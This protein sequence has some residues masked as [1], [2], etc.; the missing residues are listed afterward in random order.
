MRAISL[1][2]QL[3]QVYPYDESPKPQ[4]PMAPGPVHPS[5]APPLPFHKYFH[6]VS[7]FPSSDAPFTRISPSSPRSAAKRRGDRVSLRRPSLDFASSLRSP[8]PSSPSPRSRIHRL[9]S[10]N[11]EEREDRSLLVASPETGKLPSSPSDALSSAPPVSPSSPA[12][13]RQQEALSQSVVVRKGYPPHLKTARC[14]FFYGQCFVCVRV[15]VR[16]CV[17]VCV[18][19]RECPHVFLLQTSQ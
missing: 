16:A 14:L 1:E 3:R 17:C 8:R 9:S 19:V 18:C 10:P 15:C 7:K 13:S 6:T 12:S 5:S 2:Q 11:A 4:L